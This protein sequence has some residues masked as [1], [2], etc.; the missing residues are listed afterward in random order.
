M[1][2][3]KRTRNRVARAVAAT[4]GAIAAALVI[5][6]GCGGGSS[7]SIFV[8]GFQGTRSK[9]LTVALTQLAE[10]AI[11]GLYE[12]MRVE[13]VELRDGASRFCAAPDEASLAS[14]QSD[15]LE[16]M[17]T[18]ARARVIG[19]GPIRDENRNL[20]LHFWPDKN[21]NVSR[22]VQQLLARDT[23]LDAETIS[24]QSVPA[25]GL[26]ALE[27]L[28]FDVPEGALAAY[29][30]PETGPRRC[31]MTT[32]I[33]GNLVRIAEETLAGWDRNGGNFADEL[34]LAGQ[35][36]S[37]FA[38]RGDAL[39]EI[40]TGMITI[41]TQTRDERIRAPLAPNSENGPRP[42]QA[43]AYRSRKSLELIAYTVEGLQTV[44]RGGEP[45]AEEFGLDNLLRETEQGELDLEI[46]DRFED[47]IETAGRVPVPLEEAIF[48]PEGREQVQELLDA[49]TRM[50]RILENELSIATGVIVGFNEND[51]D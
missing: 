28:L 17:A 24:V 32:A 30:N 25:Q 19:I 3:E 21:G 2:V 39:E 12:S 48:T 34:A 40:L 47:V 6:H 33:T 23:P 38:T 4:T 1:H 9:Q 42:N 46:R 41:A 36:S 31:E 29:Q 8:E 15:W 20:R 7:D 14:L 43:E 49:A 10:S 35:G 22:A 11:P 16:A 5:T 45:R 26:S 51:G 18:W 50:T 13:L 27:F 44:Y 37:T